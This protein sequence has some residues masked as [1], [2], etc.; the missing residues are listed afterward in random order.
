[1]S[2]GRT[3]PCLFL[4]EDDNGDLLGE[5]VVKLK[6]GMAHGVTGLV[7]EL[8]AAQ[9]AKFLDIPVPE[10]AIIQVDPAITEVISDHELADKIRNS[11]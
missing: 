3:K 6:A 10:P 7:A 4:C 1:M 11:E 2:S 5:Y 9:L 8:L